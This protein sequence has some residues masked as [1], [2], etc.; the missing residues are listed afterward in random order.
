MNAAVEFH[1]TNQVPMNLNKWNA[2]FTHKF[3]IKG[4]E[5]TSKAKTP[6]FFLHFLSNQISNARKLSNKDW[7]SQYILLLLCTLHCCKSPIKKKKK[8]YNSKHKSFG[9]KLCFLSFTFSWQPNRKIKENSGSLISYYS[10]VI[11]EKNPF[12]K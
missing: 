7:T 8:N 11:A 3:N 5:I 2:Y 9:Q 6:Y 10:Q 12:K 1:D 4:Y